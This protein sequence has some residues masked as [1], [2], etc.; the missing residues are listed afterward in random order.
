MSTKI[1]IKLD[2]A[3]SEAVA[4]YLIEGAEAARRSAEV[5]AGAVNSLTSIAPQVV[6][7]LFAKKEKP[8]SHEC[9]PSEPPASEPSPETPD[10]PF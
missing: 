2:D 5:L 7:K 10:T 6:E 1:K 9:Q 4:T 3:L 8:G